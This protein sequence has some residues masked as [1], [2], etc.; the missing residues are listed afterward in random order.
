MISLLLFFTS[1]LVPGTGESVPSTEDMV[2]S[3]LAEP[4]TV[5][6]IVFYPET[7]LSITLS[8]DGWEGPLLVKIPRNFPVLTTHDDTTHHGTMVSVGG[9]RELPNTL[10][11]GEC[12]FSY[13]I[14]HQG[15]SPIQLL[16]TYHPVGTQ[17][18]V[19]HPVDDACLDRVFAAPPCE[20]WHNLRGDVVCV[21]G[22]SVEKLVQR[23]YLVRPAYGG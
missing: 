13:E 4:G 21:F 22:S 3:I 18:L 12:F 7:G 15:A 8:A 23:G 19:S 1:I 17:I 5:E 9:G 2:F 20:K 11:E 6:G 10:T 16:S 14:D